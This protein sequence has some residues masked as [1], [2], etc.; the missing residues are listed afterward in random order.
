MRH[1]RLLVLSVAALA[2]LVPG[3]SFAS[4]ARIDGLGLQSDYVQDYVNVWHYPS[5]IVRYEN[6]VYGDLGIKDE[7]GGDLPEFEDN[8]SDVPE[9][10]NSARSMGTFLKLWKGMPGTLGL[11]LNENAS[12]ISPAY[13]ADFWNRNRNESFTLAWGDQIGDGGLAIGLQLNRSES[14]AEE[15]TDIIAPY[16][17]SRAGSRSRPQSGT[18]ARS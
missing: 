14:R 10:Q 8:D 12:A 9:L 16:D 5:T 11:A 17:C 4:S 6:L 1:L 2:C 15:D 18:A 3:Q 7:T 13:G